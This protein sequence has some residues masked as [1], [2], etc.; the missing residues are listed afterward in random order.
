MRLLGVIRPPLVCHD[1]IDLSAAAF[2][3]DQ[4]LAPIEHGRFGAVSG[5]QLYRVTFHLMAARLAP[6]DQP[7]LGSGPHC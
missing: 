7:D 4:L 1:H 5:S 3:E 6:D 2:G